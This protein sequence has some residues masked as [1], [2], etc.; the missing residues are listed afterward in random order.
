MK[1]L[2]IPFSAVLENSTRLSQGTVV[3]SRQPGRFPKQECGAGRLCG[4][5][6]GEPDEARVGRICLLFDLVFLQ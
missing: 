1:Y 6:V 3:F 5:F 4:A 2:L